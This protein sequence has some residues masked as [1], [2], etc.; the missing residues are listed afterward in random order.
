MNNLP[1]NLNLSATGN[2]ASKKII[3]FSHGFGVTKDG[4]D[5]LLV[6]IENS[7]RE[8]FLCIRFDY[9]TFDKKGN[10]YTPSLKEMAKMLQDIYSWCLLEFK[11]KE[12][13]VIAHSL[14]GLVPLISGLSNI[15]Q[16]ILLAL[17]P[18]P[19]NEGLK[20]YFLQR[21]H[22]EIYT[23]KSSKIERS[24]GTFTFVEPEFW[25][26]LKIEPAKLIKP[27]S[28]KVFIT[29][30]QATK[31]QV[32]K[33]SYK[34]LLQNQYINKVQ[35]KSDHDFSGDSRESVIREINDTLRKKV[36]RVALLAVVNQDNK[37]LLQ[38]RKNFKGGLL[39]W[40]W[41]GGA[42]ELDET[43]EIAVIREAYEELGLTLLKDELKRIGHFQN[44]VIKNFILKSDVFIYKT[45]KDISEFTL[46]EGDGMKYVSLEKASKL[47]QFQQDQDIIHKL[48]K[49]I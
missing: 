44:E 2:K 41:F 6:D 23:D 46:G 15:N 49:L 12:I 20:N 13:N 43:P 18:K 7:L 25:E 9:N 45:N 39:K 1:S 31:D 26:D 21:P 11:P 28:N 36:R 29:V 5:N 10:T 48:K 24:D 32:I 47:L 34:A 16:L 30:I 19:Q 33:D 38:D 8:E 3:I 17:P 27:L 14:G 35:I 37:I 4:R 22:T 42:I 40:G